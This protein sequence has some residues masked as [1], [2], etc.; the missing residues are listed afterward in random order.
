MQVST[1]L[2]CGE[3]CCGER[4]MTDTYVVLRNSETGE[5]RKIEQARIENLEGAEFRWSEGNESCDCC[6]HIMF[7]DGGEIACGP[8][9]GKPRKYFATLMQDGVRLFT[10]DPETKARGT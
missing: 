3:A 9:P 5:S 10:D 8:L 6:R 4:K 2:V 1:A 7:G